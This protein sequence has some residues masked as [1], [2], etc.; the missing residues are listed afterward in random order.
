MQENGGGHMSKQSLVLLFFASLTGL[1]SHLVMQDN[2]VNAGEVLFFAVI[3]ASTVYM[4]IKSNV[5]KESNIFYGLNVV[6]G[7]IVFILASLLLLLILLWGTM[8]SSGGAW[9]L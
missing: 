9:H 4:A 6:L 7:A 2:R 8:Q 3:G 5:R 1:S